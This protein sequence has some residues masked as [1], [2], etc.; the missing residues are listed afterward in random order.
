MAKDG[1]ADI[2][3]KLD[4]ALSQ[5]H[6]DGTLLSIYSKYISNAEKYLGVDASDC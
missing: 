5:M 3:K 1:P 6:A 2:A 4:E